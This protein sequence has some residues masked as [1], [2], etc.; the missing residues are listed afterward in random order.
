MAML[1]KTSHVVI[2]VLAIFG[3]FAVYHLAVQHQGAG[4]L[5]SGLGT[6]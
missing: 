1:K 4:L 5:P 6:K 2:L 3:I